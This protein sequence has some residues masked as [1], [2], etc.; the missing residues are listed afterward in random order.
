MSARPLHFNAFIWPNGYH[1]SA[2]RVVENDVPRGTR[3]LLL[4]RHRP[5]RR[6]RPDGFDLSGRQHRH[7]RIPRHVPAADAVRPDLGALG[8]GRRHQPHRADRDRLDDLQQAVGARPPVCHPG[9]S[10]RRSGGWNI[11]TTVT[12]LAAANFGEPAHPGHADRYARAHEFVDVV[13]RAW[14]SWEDDAVVGDRATVSGRTAVSCTP[15]A[16]TASSTTPKECCRPPLPARSPGARSSRAVRGRRRAGRAV[17][18]AGVLRAA[19]ASGRGGLPR[20]PARPGHRRGPR[21][22]AGARP[23]RADGD[24]GRHRGR[25][26]GEGP[27]AGRADESGVPLAERAVHGRA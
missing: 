8:S 12:P 13:L 2:W 3:A 9:S 1:E 25:S 14:D 6:T 26:P 17:R 15:L 18:R 11:V 5:D 21:P 4:H 23:A 22:G 16:S 27:A 7:R 24:L 19:I 10:Q 20:R